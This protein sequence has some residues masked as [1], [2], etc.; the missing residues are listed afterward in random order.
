LELESKEVVTRKEWQYF[1]ANVDEVLLTYPETDEDF[2][3]DEDD[4][5]GANVLQ[6]AL[7]AGTD[8]EDDWTTEGTS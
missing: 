4:D 2:Y 3:T 5:E 7:N 1:T 6:P 8:G